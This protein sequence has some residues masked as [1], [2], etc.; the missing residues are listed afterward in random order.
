MFLDMMKSFLGEKRVYEKCPSTI[1]F[2]DKDFESAVEALQNTT[3]IYTSDVFIYQ[4]NHVVDTIKD[5]FGDMFTT[6]VHYVLNEKEREPLRKALVEQLSSDDRYSAA[7]QCI[8]RNA[9]PGTKPSAD[10]RYLHNARICPVFRR[11]HENRVS[12]Q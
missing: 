12:G 5:D 8:K 1:S 6:Y 11:I 7:C 4:P 9:P 10:G 3:D 2:Y